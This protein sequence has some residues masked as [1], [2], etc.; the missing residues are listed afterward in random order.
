MAKRLWTL[1]A[2]VAA[3]LPLGAL[4]DTLELTGR[5]TDGNGNAL[6]NQSFRL[7]LGSDPAPR[8]AGSGRVVT[9]DP[10]G[11]FALRAEVSLPARRI[12]LDAV[13]GRHDSRLLELG[14]EFD[15]LGQ[16]ALYWAEIDFT[17]FGPLTGLQAFVAQGANGFTTPLTF[18]PRE[19]SWSVP[20]DPNGWRLTTIGA[21]LEVVEANSGENDVWQLDISVEHQRFEVR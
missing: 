11:R 18:H 1:A 4:A 20:G 3:M 7:V 14:L 9:T 16:P 17:R 10:G 5:L 21:N 15:L 8:Q 2:V 19:F 12:E 13:G 6:G